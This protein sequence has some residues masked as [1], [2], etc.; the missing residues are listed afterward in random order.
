MTPTV[1]HGFELTTFVH[2]LPQASFVYTFY[3]F[4]I[5]GFW[6]TFGDLPLR[7]ALPTIILVALV[8]VV[9]CFGVWV[10]LQPRGRPSEETLLP[11][12]VPIQIAPIDPEDS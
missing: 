11:A 7:I 12:P 10:V 9:I 6:M 5:Q 2:G 8:F 4:V 3:L 1:S